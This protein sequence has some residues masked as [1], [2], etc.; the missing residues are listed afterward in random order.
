MRNKKVKLSTV[1]LLSITL[2]RL[3]A[4]EA[5]PASGGN[6]S[7]TGGSASYTAG[8]LVYTINTGTSGS[9][10]QGVQQP[11]EILVVTGNEEAKDINLNYAA[12]PNPATDYLTLKIE[13]NIP[14]PCIASLYDI[15][16]KL[17]YCI[18]VVSNETSIFMGEFI[19]AIYFLKVVQDNREVKNFKIIKK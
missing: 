19:P 3:Q 6:A 5:I 9:I 17:L 11:F 7:G 15:N 8:Q 13:G 18:K 4:Q 1:L 12:F 2:I 16:G 14:A 10:T